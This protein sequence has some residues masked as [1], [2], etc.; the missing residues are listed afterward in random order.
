MPE[1]SFPPAASQA[2]QEEGEEGHEVPQ[3]SRIRSHFK[4]VEPRLLRC[5]A[6]C[7]EQMVLSK[8][9]LRMLSRICFF[10]IHPSLP[11]VVSQCISNTILAIES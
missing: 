6:I 9:V 7:M 11:L 4:G 10:T 8:N 3:V 1:A 5:R 2:A